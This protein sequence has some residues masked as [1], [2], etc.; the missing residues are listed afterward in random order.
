MDEYITEIL[1]PKECK[2]IGRKISEIEKYTE[3]RLVIIGGISKN[4]NTY[5][6][7]HDQIIQEEDRF[8]IQADP[9]D[10]KLMMDEYRL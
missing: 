1:I 10:L 3:D 7:R 5:T 4:G 2:F 8:Q 6:P 9:V